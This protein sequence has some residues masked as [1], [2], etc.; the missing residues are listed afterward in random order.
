MANRQGGYR[1]EQAE[2]LEKIAPTILETILRKRAEL[3]LEESEEKFRLVA[4]FTFDWETWLGPKGN[5]IYV[6]PSC[7]RV[8]G[9]T[10]EDFMNIPVWQW[11]FCIL[12]IEPFECH[13]DVY[14]SEHVGVEEID[15]RIIT[16]NGDLRWIGHHC[17]PVFGRN[18][19][20]LGRRESNRDI[21]SRKEAEDALQHAMASAEQGRSH[22]EAIFAAQNDAVIL[23]DTELNVISANP[24]FFSTYGFDPVGLNFRDIA[25]KVA[26]RQLNGHP[27]AIEQ[28]PTPRAAQGEKVA[29]E[30]FKITRSDGTEMA[31]EISSSPIYE[32]GRIIGA[33]TVWRDISEH[34][35][36]GEELRRNEATLRG[37]L[38][39]V[40]ESIWLVLTPVATF[41]WPT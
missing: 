40:K 7:E 22:L 32:N 21:T 31:V 4:D 18:G 17:Q 3:A 8:T 20:W 30:R 6:S 16:K 39:A 1:E 33:V 24:S 14:L 36:S 11:T 29:G 27:A 37:I 41:S 28:H 9:Y 34:V 25:R 35:R 12:T 23:H 2:I 13:R 26:F 15:Y 38:D 10:A 5:Y 19:E